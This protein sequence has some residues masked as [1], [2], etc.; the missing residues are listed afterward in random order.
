MTCTE[1]A[2]TVVTPQSN[3]VTPAIPS[4][5]TSPV[6]AAVNVPGAVTDDMSVA[7]L[8]PVMQIVGVPALGYL[9]TASGLINK[10]DAEVSF[11]YVYT[12]FCR[13]ETG[14]AGL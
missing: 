7:T 10:Q 9:L 14:S 5:V 1:P 6:I 4:R 11:D 3:N 13:F 12:H 8:A 2:E